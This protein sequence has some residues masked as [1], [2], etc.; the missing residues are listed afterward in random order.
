[1]GKTIVISSHILSDIAEMCT[2]VGIMN[3]G[4]LVT[5]GRMEDILSLGVNSHHLIID[6]KGDMEAAIQK[7]R[8]IPDI[9]IDSVMEGQIVIAC[10]GEDEQINRIMIELMTGG[11]LVGGFRREE[12]NLETLFMKLTGDD[13]N[14]NQGMPQ[15]PAQG[16]MKR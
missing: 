5:A 4:R 7:V 10:S 3:R 2:S 6:V 11:V 16:G 1:M 15:G 14:V 8:E 13:I 12:Q 9:G